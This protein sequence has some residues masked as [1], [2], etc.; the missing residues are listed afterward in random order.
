[1]ICDAHSVRDPLKV[2]FNP[3]GSQD[4]WNQCQ[5]WHQPYQQHT[6]SHC[7]RGTFQ[8]LENPP[9]RILAEP[10]ISVIWV[11]KIGGICEVFRTDLEI[12]WYRYAALHAQVRSVHAR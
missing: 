1:M 5:Q 9:P 2:Y 6:L 4:L 11:A 10:A 3:V 8:Y 12:L 7:N